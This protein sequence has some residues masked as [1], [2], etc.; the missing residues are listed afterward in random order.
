MLL[1]GIIAFFGVVLSFRFPG[2][3][4]AARFM[5][6]L[7]LFVVVLIL[8]FPIYRFRDGNIVTLVLP[9]RNW[10]LLFSYF[11]AI[12]SLFGYVTRLPE[13]FNQTIEVFKYN[14]FGELYQTQRILGGAKSGLSTSNIPLVLANSMSEVVPFLF[15]SL[16]T[17]EKHLFLKFSLATCILFAQWNWVATAGRN[18]LIFFS[19]VSI[20]LIILFW[21]VLSA[22]VKSIVLS[23]LVSFYAIVSVIIII[24]TISRFQTREDTNPIDSILIYA[25][26]PMLNFCEHIYNANT[27][28]YGDMNFPIVRAIFGLDYSPSLSMRNF[29]WESKLG[30]PLGVFYTFI[31][32]IML[33]F[34]V[35]VSVLLFISISIFSVINTRRGA[36]PVMLHEMFLI[37]LLFLFLSQG[38]FYFTYKTVTGN[39]QLIFMS[40]SYLFFRFSTSKIIS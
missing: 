1:Y 39:L 30:V 26:Q 3:W 35:V 21:N 29:N 38:I 10:F 32:D 34:G 11:V 9:Q 27:F 23:S 12:I 18:G 37:Y 6:L 24:I 31:G 16:I 17:V 14:A 20:G 40:F 33:D 2:E 25:G 8:I 28:T 22:K 15:M 7:N 19:I 36:R 4:E 5:P 13:T